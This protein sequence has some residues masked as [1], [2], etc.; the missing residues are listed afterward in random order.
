MNGETYQRDRIEMHVRPYQR[1][2]CR[3]PKCM[4]KRP[5]YDHKSKTEVSWRASSINGVPVKLLYSPARICC[6][7]HGILTEYIPWQDGNSRF[8]E[9]FNN[10]VAFLALTIPKTVCAQYMGIDWKTVG[11]SVKA[12]HDRLEPDVSVRLRG[13]K[14]FCVDETSYR[15]GHKYITVV[16]DLDQNRVAWVLEQVAV[17]SGSR[18]IA[19]DFTDLAVA[20]VIGYGRSRGVGA[21]NLVDEETV[22]GVSVGL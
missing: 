9:S 11:N 18:N 16:Y 15:K 17:D 1:M 5:V 6:P 22:I 8:T 2:R 14:R 20:I 10:D 7:E 13:I 12:A 19:R 4:E 21:I 3:C